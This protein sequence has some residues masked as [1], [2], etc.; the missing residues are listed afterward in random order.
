MHLARRVFLGTAGVLIPRHWCGGELLWAAPDGDEGPRR[1]QRNQLFHFRSSDRAGILLPL[2]IY[3][4]H[5]HTHPAYNRVLEL[6]RN[7]PTVPFWVIVNPSSGPGKQVDANYARAIDRLI[8]AGCVTLAYVSTAYGR[9]E[10]GEIA[11]EL[12]RWRELYPRIHGVFFDEMRTE[13]EPS[14]VVYQR[15][16]RQQAE[17]HGYWP[18]VANPGTDTPERYFAGEVADVIVIHERDR[19]PDEARLHGNYFGGYADYPPGTR[20]VL[21]YGQRQFDPAAVRTALRH[22]RWIYVT[23]DTYRPNDPAHPNPWDDL[24]TH[25]AALCE[26]LAS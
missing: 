8:G 7:Y 16:L 13:D 26:L 18:S 5:I 19:W 20:A 10:P 23:H 3:P 21:V 4:A 17:Q 6:K 2:Y 24:S 22:V 1:V 9:K 11:G 15:S 12:S 25:L 14:G